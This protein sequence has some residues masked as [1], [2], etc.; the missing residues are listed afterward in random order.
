MIDEVLDYLIEADALQ[1]KKKS[2]EQLH[3]EVAPYLKA[4]GEYLADLN[5]EARAKLRSWGGGGATKRVVREFESAIHASYEEF[6]PEGLEQWQKES[7]GE[8]NDK[9]RPVVERLQ[10]AIRTNIVKKM[11]A[12]FGERHWWERVPLK[13]A[14]ACAVRRIDDGYK[15]PDQN[16]LMLLDYRD[17][18]R[19]HPILLINAFTPPDRASAG[20]EKRLSWFLEFNECER[21]LVG[22]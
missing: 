17:I 11:K 15:E 14:K 7:S 12:E 4:V 1:P 10:I 22:N 3:A 5:A 9:I 20:K 16:Y 8:F 21:N 13:I 2:S 6:A 19:D 18:I